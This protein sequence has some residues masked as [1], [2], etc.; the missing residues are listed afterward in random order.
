MWDRGWLTRWRKWSTCDIGEATEGLEN[1][2]WCRWSDWRGWRRRLCSFSSPSIAA[3]CHSSFSSL[4]NPFV[5]SSTSQ[6]IIQHF[7]RF[8]YIT[9]CSSTLPSLHLRHMHYTNTNWRAA[10]G[11]DPP[12]QP[13]SKYATVFQCFYFINIYFIRLSFVFSYF[14]T[15]SYLAVLRVNCNTFN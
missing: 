1:E 9:T 6:L 4:A 14:V 3:L 12:P 13:N 15:S 11:P 10:H 5:A 7:R 8:T 2:L